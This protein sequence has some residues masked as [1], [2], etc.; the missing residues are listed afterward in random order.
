MALKPLMIA[1]M[2]IAAPVAADPLLEEATEMTGEIFFLSSGVPGAV[3]GAIRDGETAVFGYGET[4]AGNGTPPDGD[5]VIRIGSITKVFAGEMLAHAVARGEAR[6]TDPVAPLTSGALGAALAGQ[7]P[8]RLMDLAMHSGGLPRELGESPASLEGFARYLAQ[9]P[10]DY[11]PG[12]AIAYS[13]FGFNLLPP[14]LETAAGSDDYAALLE[15]RI[16]GPLGMTSTGFAITADT[17]ARMMTGHDFDHQPMEDT[18]SDAVTTGS[19]ALRAPASDLMRWLSWHL[20]TLD[21]RPEGASAEMIPVMDEVRAL[22][23]AVLRPRGA[24]AQVSSMDESGHMDVMAL[25]WVAMNATQTRPFTLQKAGATHGQMSYIAMAPEH[26][27]G[28]F[29]SINAYDFAAAFQMAEMAN[30]LLA[31]ISGY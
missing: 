20:G 8:I 22:T 10:L 21:P 26:G 3:V 19:G 9:N 18:P 30:A 31:E 4:R 24:F 23:H 5:T 27:T 16:T 15:A 11:A 13:N 17:E 7:P 25:G 6:L 28:V 12:D 1:A 29:F 14:A 2:V